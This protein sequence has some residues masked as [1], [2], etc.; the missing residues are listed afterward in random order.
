MLKKMV[1][2]VVILSSVLFTACKDR[3]SESEVLADPSQGSEDPL[4]SYIFANEAAALEGLN[5]NGS[6]WKM[7]RTEKNRCINLEP[8][9][10][11]DRAYGVCVVMVSAPPA[12][13]YVSISV[14]TDE[15]FEHR[16]FKVA[17][18]ASWD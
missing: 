8:N 11:I 18:L 1:A 14:S 5:N 10:G 6:Q 17:E 2:S 15:T 12:Q 16:T 7:K 13:G 3:G 4:L 9:G